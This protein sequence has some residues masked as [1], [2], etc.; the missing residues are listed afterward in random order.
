MKRGEPPVTKENTKTAAM[1]NHDSSTAA[2]DLAEMMT[3]IENYSA[4]DTSGNMAPSEA[5]WFLKCGCTS[6]ICGHRPKL[7]WYTGFTKKATWDIRDFAGRVAGKSIGQGDVPSRYQLPGGRN[8]ID[9]E[10]VRDVLHV[11]GAHNSLSHRRLM[12]K[13]LRIVPVN[14]LGIKIYENVTTGH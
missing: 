8:R 9:E 10:V 5:S 2:S 13:G 14:G 12:D 4:T 3:A 1:A 6:D 11:E 7:V